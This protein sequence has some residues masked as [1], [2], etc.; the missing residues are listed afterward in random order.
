M[1]DTEL[2]PEQEFHQST[3]PLTEMDPHS[4]YRWTIERLL[5]EHV[6]P[7]IMEFKLENLPSS[8]S[9]IVRILRCTFRYKVQVYRARKFVF[10]AALCWQY[11]FA[12]NKGEIVF[13]QGLVTFRDRP[14]ESEDP[15]LL[16]RQIDADRIFQLHLA[17]LLQ[18]VVTICTK[19]GDYL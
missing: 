10:E 8:D 7:N 16:P 2:T 12:T 11:N 5:D 13:S 9:R 4:L 6:R 15:T 14:R 18:S 17:K 1:A 3:T 19:A